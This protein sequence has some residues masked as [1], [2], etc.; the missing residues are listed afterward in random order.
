MRNIKT[1]RVL[2]ILTLIVIFSINLFSQNLPD[3]TIKKIDNLFKTWDN[4]YSPG[5]II[6]IIRND[7]LIYS[8]GYGMANL[9]FGAPITTETVFHMAS[10]S[11]QFTAYSIILLANRGKLKLDDD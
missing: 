2:S 1:I 3:S 9:E 11:K 7:S 4:N 8:K 10:V 6:G 5:C